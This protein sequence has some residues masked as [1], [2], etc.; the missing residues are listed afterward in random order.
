MVQLFRHEDKTV[1]NLTFE[2]EN[3]EQEFIQATPEHPFMLESGQWKNAG[4]LL[5][6]DTVQTHK[7]RMVKVKSIATDSKRH[8]VYTS[9]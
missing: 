4:H 7:D 1:L 2:T 9:K 5:P 3:G 6:G 8:K